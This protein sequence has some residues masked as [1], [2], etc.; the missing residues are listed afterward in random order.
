MDASVMH[1]HPINWIGTAVLLDTVK[2]V[3]GQKSG[4]DFHFFCHV[5]SCTAKT[6]KHGVKNYIWQFKHTLGLSFCQ[7]NVFDKLNIFLRYSQMKVQK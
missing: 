2:H 4:N 7:Q 5:L 3:Y 6:S 1:L